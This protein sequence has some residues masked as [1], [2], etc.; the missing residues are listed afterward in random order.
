MGVEMR[1]GAP[2]SIGTDQFKYPEAAPNSSSLLELLKVAAEE[3]WI[4]GRGLG[5]VRELFTRD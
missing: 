3:V 2:V 1:D 5:G 4:G